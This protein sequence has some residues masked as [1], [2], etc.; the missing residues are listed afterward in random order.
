MK[1]SLIPLPRCASI[2]LGGLFF[3]LPLTSTLAQRSVV[4]PARSS[5]TL[6]EA[7]APQ[8]APPPVKPVAP[9][10]S[11]LTNKPQF[12][13]INVPTALPGKG[14]VLAQNSPL[15]DPVV[16]TNVV[17]VQKVE[18]IKA[19][20][21]VAT[22]KRLAELRRELR[23]AESASQARIVLPADELFIATEETRIDPLA[24]PAL[25]DLVE[26][27]ERSLLKNVTIKARHVPGEAN[28]QEKAWQRVLALMNWLQKNS[29]LDPDR[30]RAAVPQ[31]LD[32]PSPKPNAT[33]LGESEYIARIELH[34]Y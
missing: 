30:I 11:S 1:R 16:D 31:V 9:L 13:Q 10:N 24:V 23:I 32:K 4:I 8:A 17:A 12:S 19:A 33:T 22:V 20:Q 15:A 7:T 18:P 25:R 6:G 14:S 5:S 34:L 27:L 29:S 28:G 2:V 26:Y 21:D 3:A